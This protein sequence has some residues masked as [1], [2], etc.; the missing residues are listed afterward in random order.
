MDWRQVVVTIIGN[1]PGFCI[2]RLR[3]AV[4]E[5]VTAGSEAEFRTS[6]SAN[7]NQACWCRFLS[8]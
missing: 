6:Y 8:F 4:E 1:C 7:A 5:L 2:W 3:K